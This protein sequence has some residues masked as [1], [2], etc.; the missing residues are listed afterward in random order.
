MKIVLIVFLVIVLVGGVCWYLLRTESA[1]PDNV[2]PVTL[3]D[4]QNSEVAEQIFKSE[5]GS[6]AAVLRGEI[7]AVSGRTITLQVDDDT[8]EVFIGEQARIK[9]PSSDPQIPHKEIRDAEISGVNEEAVV[10]GPGMEPIRI[11]GLTVTV[12]VRLDG[13][14]LKTDYFYLYDAIVNISGMEKIK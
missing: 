6:I 13:D 1:I 14:F 3:S 7:V 11:F 12:L 9:L 2:V 4:L 5:S 8:L 10:T